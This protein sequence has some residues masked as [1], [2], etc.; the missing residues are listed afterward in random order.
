MEGHFLIQDMA[1]GLAAAALYSL[2]LLAPGYVLGSVTGVLRFREADRLER[3]AVSLVL[4]IGVLP[5]AAYLIARLTSV[6]IVA[7]WVV[8]LAGVALFIGSRDDAA[9]TGLTGARARTRAVAAI[10]LW[11]LGGLFLLSDTQIGARLYPSIVAFDYAKHI[12]VTDAITRTNVPPTNPSFYPGHPLGLFYYYFWFLLCSVVDTLGGSLIG[13]RGAVLGGTIWAGVG[14]A[15]ITALYLMRDVGTT[16]RAVAVGI[17]LLCISGLDAVAVAVQHLVDPT[18][19]AY[20]SIEWWNE[21]ITA[22]PTAVLWVPHHVAACIAALT[23]LLI[24]REA[25][26]AGRPSGT[27]VVLAGLCWASAAGL[28]IWVAFTFALF[29]AAWIAWML[30][31]GDRREAGSAVASAGVALVAVFP[32]AMDLRHA[33]MLQH[34]PIALGIRMFRPIDDGLHALGAGWRRIMA[35]NALAL[36]LNYLIELGVFAVGGWLFW[37]RRRFMPEG[38]AQQSLLLLTAISLLVGTFLQST[39]K[40]N[41][42]GWR[43]LMFAQFALLL[44]TAAAL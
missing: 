26:D 12:A 27:A 10:I 9:R 32:F 21:Q 42:L 35:F 36:P 39:V 22:W 25:R 2:V 28:S 34:A 38:R 14:L 41:D 29:W 1:E 44:W 13:P 6:Q 43:S 20:P 4:S 23:G 15:A 24:F 37:R 18:R 5:I 7:A 30:L 19:E 3:V 16:G 11:V 31:G 8:V 33:D 40:S 17:A